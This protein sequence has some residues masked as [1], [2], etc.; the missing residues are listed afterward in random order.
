MR[1][2]LEYAWAMYRLRHSQGMGVSFDECLESAMRVYHPEEIGHGRKSQV[3]YDSA[4]K[5]ATVDPGEL[6][7]ALKDLEDQYRHHKVLLGEVLTTLTLP[8]NQKHFDGMPE[9]WDEVVHL[10]MKKARKHG[11]FEGHQIAIE[12]END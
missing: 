1:E 11:V 4:T 7:I 5:V 10:W 8:E 12:L 9:H 2:E 3:G 6:I